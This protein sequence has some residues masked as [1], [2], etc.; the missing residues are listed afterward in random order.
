MEL[1]ITKPGL[2]PKAHEDYQLVKSAI[3]GDQHAY[4]ILHDRYRPSVYNHLYKMVRNHDDAE[5]LTIEA[6]GKAFNKLST[7][8]PHFAFSTWL[9]KIA[10]NNCIDYIRKKRLHFLSIDQ[11]MEPYSEKDFTGSLRAIAL[12]PEEDFIRCQ[13]LQMVRRILTH[14]NTKYRLMIELRY[15]QELSY[16]EIAN[17]LEIPLGTVKA[18]LFRAKEMLS[19]LMQQPGASAYLDSTRRYN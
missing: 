3:L 16:E 7:Y 15:Y 18:Q 9:F 12:N 8:A 13:R 17:E 4:A 2:S 5:D 6:F 11:P 19:G 1:T 10:V 14:L